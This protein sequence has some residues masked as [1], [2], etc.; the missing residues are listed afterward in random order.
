MAIDEERSETVRLYKFDGDEKKWHEWSNK[1]ISLA[2]AKGYSSV[3]AKDTKPCSDD[4]Y[5]TTEDTKVKTIYEKNDQ[6]YQFLMQSCSGIAFGLVNMAKTKSLIYGDA[7]KAWENLRSRYAPHGTSDLI[8]LSGDFNKCKLDNEKIDPEEWFIELDTI[9]SKMMQI[10]E[11]FGKKDAEMIAHIIDALPKGYSEVVTVV[12][13]M[14]SL[15]LQE[16]KAKIRAFYKRRFKNEKDKNELALFAGGKFKGN[17]KNCGKQGHKAAECRS[18]S[19]TAG[20]KSKVNQGVKCFNCNKFAGHYARDCPESKR[21][22]NENTKTETGMFIGM[23]IEELIDDDDEDTDEEVNKIYEQITLAN[24]TNNDDTN[25]NEN[26]NFSILFDGSI[27]KWLGDTGATSH[28]TYSDAY[29]TNVTHVKTKVTVGDGNEV[30]CTK[31]G[32]ILI[33]TNDSTQVL[34]KNVLYSPDFHQNIISIGRFANDGN[35]EV[36]IKGNVLSVSKPRMTGS[37][38]FT[39]DQQGV[40]FY[41]HGS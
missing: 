33:M 1:A 31:R 27:E 12:E 32:D 20:D 24:E 5:E 28:V 21:N 13:G 38:N 14:S 26:R 41:L 19:N 37:L 3:Y 11:S 17:C 40:L 23:M 2:H 16:L 10:D 29:M 4:E 6:A 39:C 9:S 25:K 18:K 30:V 22:K 15:T 35:Y 7:F 36:L 34:L 8:Q